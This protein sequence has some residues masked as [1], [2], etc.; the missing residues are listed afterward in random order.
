LTVTSVKL[1]GT[2]TQPQLWAR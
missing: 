2:H 1:L